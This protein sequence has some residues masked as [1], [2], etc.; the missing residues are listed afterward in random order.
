MHWVLQHNVFKEEAFDRL[1]QV[2]ERFNI[3]HSFHRVVPFVGTLIP[4]DGC[5]L[6]DMESYADPMLPKLKNPVICIGSYS[7]RH[8]AKKYSWN[9]GVFDLME[10]GNFQNCMKHWSDLML[11]ADSVVIPFKDASW[12]SGER[13]I[14][15]TDDSKYFAG[16]MIEADEFLE[17]QKNV[18]VLGL[19]YGNSLSPDTLIQ[20]A[21]PKKIYAEYRCWVVDS[22][23]VTISLYKRGDKVIYINMDDALGDQARRFANSVLN[24]GNIFAISGN[25]GW[26]PSRAFCLDVCETDIGWKI[27]EI[28]TINSCGFYAANL[29]SLVLA[30]ENMKFV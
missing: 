8:A 5:D 16:R 28:N 14:R 1:V 19:D 24:Y 30:L 29:T 12:V 26:Q 13:F 23:I 22:K 27:V 6:L 17:W 18:C 11:N 2:L 10:D 3:S 20:I 9:P 21:T 7:M 15:P 4:L 25:H